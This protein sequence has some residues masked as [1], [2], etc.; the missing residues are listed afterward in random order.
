[1]DFTGPRG[2]LEPANHGE[3][4]RPESDQMEW[5]IRQQNLERFR[6]LL[7]QS[8]DEPERQQLQKLLAEEEAKERAAALRPDGAAA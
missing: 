5:F 8:P 2:I 7:A 3:I 4:P 1:M 6:R